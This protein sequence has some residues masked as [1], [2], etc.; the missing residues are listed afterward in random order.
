[1]VI[2]LEGP[3]LSRYQ[4]FLFTDIEFC[5][6]DVANRQDIFDQN[7][8]S[9]VKTFCKLGDRGFSELNICSKTCFSKQTVSITKDR[10]S[11]S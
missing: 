6:L 1:M 2:V 7:I 9:G 3:N 5:F 10:K 11:T 8:A 4:E